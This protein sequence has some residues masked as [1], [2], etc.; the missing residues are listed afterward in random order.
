MLEFPSILTHH[1][2]REGSLLDV[3][4][5]IDGFQSN[6]QWRMCAQTAHGN[7]KQIASK[8]IALPV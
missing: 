3:L 4:R 2:D 6:G 5:S 1:T 8:K 7:G